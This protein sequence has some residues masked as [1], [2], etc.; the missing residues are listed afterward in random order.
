MNISTQLK[1]LALLTSMTLTTTT[2]L[3]GD[4]TKASPYTPVELNAQKEALAASGDT[5]WVKADLKGLGEDGQSTDNADTEDA[6][7]KSVK[8]LAA[9]FGDEKENF[10][11]YSWAILGQL[12]LEDLTNTKDLL[13]A[14]TYGTT[15]HYYNSQ[16]SYESNGNKYADSYEPETEHFSLVAVEGALSVKIE[17]GLRGYHIPSSYV[18]P[19]KVIAV[20]VSAGYSAKNGAYVNYTN[21]DGAAKDS[22]NVVTGKDIAL[23]LMAQDGTYD[24]TLT[25]QYYNQTM[26]NGNALNV[27]TA[28]LNAGTTKNRTRLAFVNDGTKVGF[29]KNSNENC[30]VTLGSK[31]DVF[32]QVSSLETN[33]YGN[34]AWETEAKDWITWAGGQYSDFHAIEEL[35]TTFLFDFVNNNMGL[36]VGNAENL[37]AGDLQGKSVTVG[38][39]TLSFD[40]TAA[41]SSRYFYIESK[42]GN[43]LNMFRGDS[44]TVTAAEGRALTGISFAFQAGSS[45]GT[46]PSNG[47]FGE[48]T[49]AKTIAW[50]GN[51]TQVSFPF[52]G[53][54]YI[55][56]IS[57]TTAEADE[58]TVGIA[59]VTT[60][61]PKAVQGIYDLMGRRV[62]NPTKGLYIVNGKKVYMK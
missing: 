14:L 59:T 4:G 21:F 61:Q 17:N 34:Y 38:E 48:F 6:E 28:G 10:V 41:T 8:N 20:K 5:V 49:E 60:P 50:S 13:I 62:A 32:L 54:R 22:V 57:V 25:T 46:T 37:N 58:N 7:G 18:I 30:T 33:F 11:A 45:A 36:P 52:T 24:F 43:L 1:T 51:A 56:S 47:E 19:E 16:S 3:A 39:V 27:G 9:L 31:T 44:I 23:I 26:S 35:S 12:A 53:T 2:A 55:Y 42:G 29:E 15:V 40:G